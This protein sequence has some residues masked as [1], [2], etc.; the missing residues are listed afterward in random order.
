MQTLREQGIPTIDLSQAKA[1]DA[2]FCHSSNLF[3]KAIRFGQWILRLPYRTWNHIAW[4]DRPVY[5]AD[6]VTIT[7]WYVG[8]AIARGVDIDHLLSTVSP[9]GEHEIVPLNAFPRLEPAGLYLTGADPQDWTEVDRQ[10]VLVELRSQVGDKYGFLTIASE[11]FTI[12]TPKFLR[13][14]FR[15]SN[16][17]ICSAVYSWGLHAG[18][19]LVEGDVYQRLPAQVAGSAA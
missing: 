3:G 8:Q 18:G 9:H 14:D 10:M 15:R 19:G 6:G 16:T 7:D 11:I 17:W 5:A 2:V 1:G 4:L 13:L 12:L